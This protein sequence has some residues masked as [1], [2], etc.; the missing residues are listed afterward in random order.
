MRLPELTSLL[1][2]IL[3]SVTAFAQSTIGFSNQETARLEVQ[4]TADKLTYKLGEPIS[5]TVILRNVGNR[6]VWMS[7]P[8]GVGIYPGEFR[9]DARGPDGRLVQNKT[10]VM[11]AAA[12]QESIIRPGSKLL[13]E[14]L[15]RRVPLF[16]GEFWGIK[17]N[18][19]EAFL[20]LTEPGR[21]ELTAK[22]NEYSIEQDLSQRQLHSLQSEVKFPIQAESIVSEVLIIEVR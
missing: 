4:L 22:Y 16:P 11:A 21:Y 8:R 17:R 12:D 10:P 3:G 6:I 7:K 18:I 9:I 20:T 2:I 14:F 5:I 13:Q 1:I 19:G 15:C